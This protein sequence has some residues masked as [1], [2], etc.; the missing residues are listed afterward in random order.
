MF[1]AVGVTSCTWQEENGELLGLGC[2]EH[3]LGVKSLQKANLE[4]KLN[5]FDKLLHSVI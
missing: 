2:S 4:E 1:S 3:P 5:C